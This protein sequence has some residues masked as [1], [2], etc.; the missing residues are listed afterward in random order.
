[1]IL[2]DASQIFIANMLQQSKGKLVVEENLIRHMILNSIRV[3]NHR[4]GKE[5][6]EFIL[7]FDGKNNWRKGSLV[8]PNYKAQRATRKEQS[9]F[10]WKQFYEIFDKIRVEIAE[11]MPYRV[12]HIAECEADDI[13]A[14]MT[15]QA[16]ENDESV[17]IVSDDKDFLQLLRYNEQFG[18]TGNV[19]IY[20]FRHKKF[21]TPDATP[22]EILVEH[23]LR[24]DTS[25]GVPNVLSDDD[26]FVNPDKRQS[27][28]RKNRLEDLMAALV[29][30]PDLKN[31][32]TKEYLIAE[33]VF[34]KYMRNLQLIDFEQIPEWVAEKV[35]AESKTPIR[36]SNGMIADYFIANQMKVLSES[37]TEF[38]R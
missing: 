23:I 20:S 19:Q 32:S 21:L 26:A 8:Y 30:E 18:Y 27:P 11:V 9:E 25:D 37:T 28:L 4:F 17:T 5:N 1:V 34:N 13:I 2:I 10:D 36:G 31:P 35:I 3:L 12:M 15:K 22:K 6:G 16:V 24:G 14:V 29:N 7:C 38:F 33:G